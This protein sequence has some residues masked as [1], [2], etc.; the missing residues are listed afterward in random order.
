[1]VES[2]KGDRAVGDDVAVKCLGGFI[3]DL[4]ASTPV[5]TPVNEGQEYILILS[6]ET[7][8]NDVP[9]TNDKFEYYP[10]RGILADDGTGVFTAE[11]PAISFTADGFR[12]EVEK[13][14]G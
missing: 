4:K 1:M 10:P 7:D 13:I 3:G 6:H 14:L 11:D 9:T 2:Y 8:E 5:E 12:A